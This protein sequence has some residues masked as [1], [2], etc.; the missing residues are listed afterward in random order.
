MK[1]LLLIAL[2]VTAVNL[3]I[4]PPA[5]A[6]AAAADEGTTPASVLS[7]QL[8]PIKLTGL[9]FSIPTQPAAHVVGVSASD[10]QRP[11]NLRE[12]LLSVINSFDRQGN[13]QQGFAYG[14]SGWQ[15]GQIKGTSGEFRRKRT[16]L[17]TEYS[18][19]AVKGATEADPSAKV[20]IGVSLPLL[21]NTQ[22]LQDDAEVRA[23]FADLNKKRPDGLPTII[24]ELK[25]TEPGLADLRE[26]ATLGEVR[27][28][29]MNPPP[30][31]SLKDVPALHRFW[32][33]RQA[34]A[35]QLVKQET[36]K[37]WNARALSLSGAYG[38]MSPTGLADDFRSDSYGVWLRGASPRGP[39][40]QL[41]YAAS[42][43]NREFVPDPSNKDAFI[44]QN[45]SQLG[46]RY[47]VGQATRSVAFE[48]SYRFEKPQDRDTEHVWTYLFGYEQR[49]AEDQWLQASVGT[50]GNRSTGSKVLFGLYY[51]IGMGSKP[52]LA[53]P[54]GS[55]R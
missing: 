6:E 29:L 15:T 17:D 49:V 37:R 42:Y 19:A 53:L 33:M 35:D 34:A 55:G 38:W 45:A 50:E 27:D 4:G 14:I 40:G 12:L 16:W 47:R 10:V 11:N 13:L 8:K 18:I 54:S 7:D 48:V 31:A 28:R 22:P 44:R 21:D 20:G 26:D 41:L 39:R 43:R 46:V 2:V 24:A 51:N 52:Q 36:E 5:Q 1:K 30:G 25:N 32:A 3:R 9:D 23:F